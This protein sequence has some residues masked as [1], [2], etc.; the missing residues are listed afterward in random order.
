MNSRIYPVVLA[1]GAITRSSEKAS[2]QSQQALASPGEGISPLQAAALATPEGSRFSAPILVASAD[3]LAHALSQLADVGVIPLATVVEPADRGSALAVA[4]AAMAVEDPHA[5]LLVTPADHIID[6]PLAL[7]SALETAVPLA[8]EGRLV[9][10]GVSA[11]QCSVPNGWI[12]LGPALAT[13]AFEVKAWGPSFEGSRDLSEPDA[14][15]WISGAF[16]VR[17]DAFLQ[18]LKRTRPLPYSAIEQAMTGAK[19]KGG[20]LRPSARPYR[21]AE[22]LLIDPVVGAFEGAAVVRMNSARSDLSSWDDV[23]SQSMRDSNDNAFT[24][25]VLASDVKGSLIQSFGPRV[26]IM[27]VSD[28][29]VVADQNEVLILRRGDDWTPDKESR[30]KL[31]LSQHRQKSKPG[32]LPTR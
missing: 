20:V 30:F 16:L 9:S 12:G 7:H 17:S 18:H 14:R 1:I 24:G 26:R 19:L 13:D 28:V 3:R 21:S 15:L 10:L 27:G 31:P 23:Y 8:Q 11:D 4:A 32:R 29:I 6:D 22:H 2:R 5:C 25:H